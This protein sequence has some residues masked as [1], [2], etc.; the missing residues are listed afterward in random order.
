MRWWTE[1][2]TLGVARLA[3]A[4][5]GLRVF[6]MMMAVAVPSAIHWQWWLGDQMTQRQ[7]LQADQHH[8]SQQWQAAERRL[9]DQHAMT[10][11]E[12]LDRGAVL[13]RW[14]QTLDD[15]EWTVV[16]AA[17]TEGHLVARLEADW[18][19]WLRG[20]EALNRQSDF[21]VRLLNL[22]VW[23]NSGLAKGDTSNLLDIEVTLTAVAGQKIEPTQWPSP[24]TSTDPFAAPVMAKAVVTSED[25]LS[26]LALDQLTIAGVMQHRGDWQVLIQAPQGPLH[27]RG[28]GAVLGHDGDV[29]TT[30]NHR[31]VVLYGHDG[32]RSSRIELPVRR[33]E[34]GASMVTRGQ[35]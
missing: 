5:W 13:D 3:L 22:D 25:P 35:P 27:R 23:V 24:L 26:Q 10:A 18:H 31:Q 15:M 32:L 17:V 8:L 34:L 1:L 2:Q 21:A 12:D 9:R 28:L 20:L 14:R 7:A 4:S 33:S 11:V 6:V 19:S 30:I 29:I 16:E